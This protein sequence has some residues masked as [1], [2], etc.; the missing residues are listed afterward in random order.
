MLRAY[1]VVLN[2]VT[3]WVVF[4]KFCKK[5]HWH[6]PAEGH[7]EAHC[8]DSASDYWKT[9]YNLVYAG[10]WISDGPQQI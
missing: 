4:C 2:G 9:G 6:G 7:R 8:K 1:E 10:E 5:W 3:H